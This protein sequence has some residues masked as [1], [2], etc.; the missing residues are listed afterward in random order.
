MRVLRAMQK[1]SAIRVVPVAILIHARRPSNSA[2]RNVDRNGSR[3][4]LL[5]FRLMFRE[6]QSN[7]DCS[8]V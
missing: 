7:K 4:S 6:R 5:V 8:A 2:K 3:A 1:V